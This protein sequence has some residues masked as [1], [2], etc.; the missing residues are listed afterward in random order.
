MALAH[1]ITRSEKN[2]LFKLTKSYSKWPERDL[3]LL[4][5]FIGTP[6]TILELNRIT[7][8]DVLSGSDT[9]NKSFTIR[10][11]K[12]LNGEYREVFIKQD[13]AKYLSKYLESIP[14]NLFDNEFLFKTLSGQPFSI[15]TLKGNQ[16]ADSLT[17]HVLDLLRESGIEQPSALSGRRT[18]ATEANRK[19]IHISVIH[20]SLG[21]KKLITTKRLIDSDPSIIGEVSNKAY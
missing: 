4:A 1:L 10:G 19:G 16:R 6:C 15:T 3:C 17:R 11:D 2:W 8:S 21:N 13:I 12:A 14:N 20:H 5:F 18:F 9:I 7:L